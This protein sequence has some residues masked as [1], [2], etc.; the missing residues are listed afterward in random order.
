MVSNLVKPRKKPRQARSRELVEAIVEAA[1][2]VFDREGTAATT[3]RIAAEAGVSIGSLYQYFPNKE[4]LLYALAERHVAQGWAALR[5]ASASLER[6]TRVEGLAARLVRTLV[7]LHAEH[8][9][10]HDILGELGAASQGTPE[11]AEMMQRVRAMLDWLAGELE[12]HL[13]RLRPDLAHPERR[14]RLVIDTIFEAVHRTSVG[15]DAD[16]VYVDEIVRLYASYLAS[17][18]PSA[19]GEA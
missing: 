15:V 7:D 11:A 9:R 8:P 6:E 10:M 17:P 12:R 5:A 1:A 13:R 18:D 16:A 19:C 3:N 2:R 14:A 4:A